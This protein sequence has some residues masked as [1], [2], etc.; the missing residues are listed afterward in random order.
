MRELVNLC[1]RLAALYEENP[2]TEEE[3][4]RLMKIKSEG[5][6]EKELQEKR[7]PSALPGGIP[8]VERGEGGITRLE[9]MES[10]GILEALRLARFNQSQ[11]ARLLGISRTT[12]W[13]KLKGM[14]E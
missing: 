10:L 1:E 5:C 12:L 4:E 7:D 2:I 13:R 9:D 3:M 11:A 14:G 8:R 6:N